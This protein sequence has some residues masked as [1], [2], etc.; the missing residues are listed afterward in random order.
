MFRFFAPLSFIIGLLFVATPVNAE[1]MTVYKS[2]YCGCCKEWV[3]HVEAAGY[4]VKVVNTEDMDGIKQSLNVP[5]PAH[6][7]HTAL[8]DGYIIE[9]HVPVSDIDRLL[10]ERPKARGLAV[11]GMPV[12]SPG[13]EVPGTTPDRYNVF[14]FDD[15]GATVYS[16]Y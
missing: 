13:M 11:P 8:I 3:N 4:S 16:Q 1:E 12:G 15:D 10:E 14:L 9:G 5:E 6:S 7:C 2:P